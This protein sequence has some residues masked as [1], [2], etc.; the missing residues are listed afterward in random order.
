MKLP[1]WDE[2]KVGDRV[3]LLRT[4][5]F[6]YQC[7]DQGRNPTEGVVVMAPGEQCSTD[8]NRA[9]WYGHWHEVKWC[10]GISNFYPSNHLV[11]SNLLV[12]DDGFLQDDIEK[13]KEEFGL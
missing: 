11:H 10:N 5:E 4:S 3:K 2:F 1:Q 7:L 8:H 12:A 6:Y 13:V 9:G